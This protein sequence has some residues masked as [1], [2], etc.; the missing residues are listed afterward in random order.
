M[1]DESE[2]LTAMCDD[3]GCDDG[4]WCRN[5]LADVDFTVNGLCEE[6]ARREKNIRKRE[7]IE[8]CRDYHDNVKTREYLGEE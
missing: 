7:S 1:G 3:G 8:M 5:C 2:A 6:C 4:D